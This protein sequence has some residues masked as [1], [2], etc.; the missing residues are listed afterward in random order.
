M[1]ISWTNHLFR[2]KVL[3]ERG[4]LVSCRKEFKYELG[5]KAKN[6]LLNKDLLHSQSRGGP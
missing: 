6:S 3:Q 4:S 2:E 1:S 5:N